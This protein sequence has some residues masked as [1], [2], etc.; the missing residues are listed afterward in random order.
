MKWR[1]TTSATS[2]STSQPT[3]NCVAQ[4]S[5]WR[6]ISSTSSSSHKQVHWR[7][8]SL[9]RSKKSQRRRLFKPSNEK[10]L[11]VNCRIWRM[12][13]PWKL[14]VTCHRCVRSTKMD[15][16]RLAD[17][18]QQSTPSFY[19]G[20][21]SLSWSFGKHMFRMV[22]QEQSIP[23]LS[24]V[25]NII[26]W[27]AT[28]LLR[29]WFKPVSSVKSNTSGQCNSRWHHYHRTEPKSEIHPSHLLG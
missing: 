16:W 9:F 14:Q 15:F 24:W 6:D 28:A 26:S 25:R 7:V 22:T 5:G 1:N 11:Q 17:V 8:L 12:E 29:R 20:I 4:L 10:N 19:Q 13:E 21:M 3:T 23:E 18:N 2:S 27:R